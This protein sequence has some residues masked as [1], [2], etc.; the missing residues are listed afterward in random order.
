L[1]IEVA[2]KLSSK[3]YAKGKKNLF[4]QQVGDQPTPTLVET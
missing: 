4:T 1:D 2:K 3:K